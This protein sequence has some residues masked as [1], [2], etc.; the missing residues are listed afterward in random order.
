VNV[1]T[2]LKQF[3]RDEQGQDLTEYGLLLAFIALAAMGFVTGAAAGV[4]NIQNNSNSNLSA[5]A[6]SV[7]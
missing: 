2:L 6:S 1:T 4:T 5:M 3:L 7:R